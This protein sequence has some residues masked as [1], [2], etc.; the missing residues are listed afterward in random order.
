MS[1]HIYNVT[2][3]V[4]PR[5]ENEW[6]RWMK[7]VHIPEVINTGMFE[8]FVFTQVEVEGQ[9]YNSYS[10]Q[11]Y[12]KDLESIKLYTQMYAPELK[13]KH[14]SKYGDKALGFRTLLRVID[15]S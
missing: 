15:K 1:E 5:I 3:A 13:E 6:V 8:R 2:I 7:E 10:V 9:E 12:A 14:N 4:D 11:Y